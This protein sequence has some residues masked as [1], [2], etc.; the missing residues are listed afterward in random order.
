MPTHE[1]K[2]DNN[3]RLEL[4]VGL[5]QS[6][7]E[8][9]NVEVSIY[10][11]N[12]ERFEPVIHGQVKRSGCCNWGYGDQVVMHFC[13]RKDTQIFQIAFDQAMLIMSNHSDELLDAEYRKILEE[14]NDKSRD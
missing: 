5:L 10:T 7:G 2:L 14:G 3:W 1:V 12:G 6:D 9:Y 4:T 8:I 13:G 11:Q